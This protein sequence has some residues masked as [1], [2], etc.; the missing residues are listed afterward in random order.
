MIIIGADHAGFILKE[1][2]K[3]YL[4]KEGFDVVDVGA[5]KVDDADDFSFYVKLLAKA[6]EQ[7][8]NNFIISVCG[9][10]VGMNVGLNKH[11]GIR[12][13]VGHSVEEV[14][15]ARE[16]NDVNALSLSGRTT[17]LVLAKKMV[18]AFLDTKSI[19]GKYEKRMKDIE[20]L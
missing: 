6:F 16:H 11:K 15:L 8:K 1:K 9:S 12:S 13:V 19:K 2:V 14:M 5:F 7:D 3:K 17:S 20:I 10:G 18:K 4:Q